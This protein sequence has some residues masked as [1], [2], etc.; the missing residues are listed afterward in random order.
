[1]AER[2]AS[3][4]PPLDLLLAFEASARLR[5][6]TRAAGERFVT[7]SAMSRQI[8]ALE[9]QLGVPLF[10]R[11]PRTLAL[12]ADGERLFATCSA[13]LAQL[14]TTVAE[15]RA[16]QRRQ[17]VSLTTL[18]GL[19]SLWLIPRLARFTRAHPGLDVRIDATFEKRQLAA[20]GF[21]LA[22][23]HRSVGPGEG[24][25][26]F[27]ESTQPVCSPALLAA[28]PPLETPADLARHTLLQLDPGPPVGMPLEWAPWLATVGLPELQPQAWLSF[29]GYGEAITAALLGQGVALGR[30]P[31]VDGLLASGQ[32]VTPFADRAASPFGYHVVVETSARARPAVRA[33]ERWLLDEAATTP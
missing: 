27:A 19:A 33:L 17:V 1:M 6:F 7:Q 31:L 20:D 25:P 3:R 24:V 8:R 18:P 28:G 4:L 11:R 14:R 16:P 30:R 5:S 23:R 26:L 12:T 13:V 15:I 10:E 29:S 22:I 21:D 9:D 32:L 2:E